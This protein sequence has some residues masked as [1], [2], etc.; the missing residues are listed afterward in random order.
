MSRRN[1][2]LHCKQTGNT[3]VHYT[4]VERQQQAHG[5][6]TDC[7]HSSSK[8][9]SSCNCS[10][11]RRSRS[12]L[13]QSPCP[14]I[15]LCVPIFSLEGSLGLSLGVRVRVGVGIG[16]P[17][18]LSATLPSSSAV[19]SKPKLGIKFRFFFG[20]ADGL[21]SSP[22]TQRSIQRCQGPCASLLA[23]SVA[24]RSVKGRRHNIF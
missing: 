19:P 4:A 3:T 13:F 22:T 21:V 14:L 11:S 2:T 10:G 15:V 20:R 24:D 7:T 17:C 16:I 18:V 9:R 1:S 12:L 6:F 8:C 23:V 5:T